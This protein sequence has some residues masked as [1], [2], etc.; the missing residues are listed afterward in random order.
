M[1]YELFAVAGPSWV[2][3]VTAYQNVLAAPVAR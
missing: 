1:R 3:R 2:S